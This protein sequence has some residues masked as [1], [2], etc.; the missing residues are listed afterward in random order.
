[1]PSEGGFDLLDEPWIV[2]LAPDGRERELSILGVFERAPGLSMIGGEVSTQAFAIT[3]LL[4]AFLHRA[5]DGPEDQHAWGELWEQPALPMTEIREYAERVRHR[6]DLFHP[7]TPFFQVADLRT[8]RDEVAGLEKIVADVPNGEPMFTTRSAASLRTIRPAEAAR[9]LVH[10]HAFDPSGIKS[11][12]VGDPSVKNGKGYPIGTGWSGQLGGVLPQ[13]TDL[14]ETLL[15]NL[16]GRDAAEYVQV[17]D[18]TDV[19]P[20]ERQPDTAVW[21]ERPPRGAIDLY[22]WQTRRVRLVG[23]RDGVTGVRLA[24]GDKILPQNRHRLEPHTAWRYSD[25]QSKKLKET[26]YMPREHDPNRSV[27]RGLAAVLPS[28]SPRRGRRDEPSAYLAPGVLQ[29]VAE[30]GAEGMLPDDYVV[31]ARVHG[32]EYGPQSATVTE[33][34]DD[35]LPLPVILLQQDRPDAGRT[36]ERAVAD[37]EDAASCLWRFA[38][39]LAQAAGAERK[40]GAG[41]RTRED[42][43]ALLE[44]PYRSWL[45]GLGPSRDLTEARRDWQHTVLGASRTVSGQLITA[46]PASAWTG[47]ELNGRPVNV[48]LAEV[49]FYAALRKALPLAFTDPATTQDTAATQLEATA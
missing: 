36:A 46:A 25:P 14:R 6:F 3:R 26:V 21:Q 7:E 1:M 22:T 4:L 11:G 41:D 2:A 10:V 16:V 20:W 34:V 33:I 49:W 19:P 38:E 45:A 24:N 32:A 8:G 13:G 35:T 9:W 30:L 27:W 5:I 47:R 39:N 28:I 15:L 17:G 18:R 40:S 12:A 48:P 43:Y 37:A 29:W 31:G 23:H 44:Q 42:L